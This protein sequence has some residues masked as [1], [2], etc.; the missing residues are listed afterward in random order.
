MNGQLYLLKEAKEEIVKEQDC[1][2]FLQKLEKKIAAIY[3]EFIQRTGN[4]YLY[5]NEQEEYD[6]LK[7]MVRGEV[8]LVF[9]EVYAFF[10]E[11]KDLIKMEPKFLRQMLIFFNQFLGYKEILQEEEKQKIEKILFFELEC[12]EDVPFGYSLSTNQKTN[13]LVSL[14]KSILERKDKNTTEENLPS[15]LHFLYCAITYSTLRIKDYSE[16]EITFICE[17]GYRFLEE[18]V[19]QK[20]RE[21]NNPYLL[22]LEDMLNCYFKNYKPN[23]EIKPLVEK[24]RTRYKEKMIQKTLQKLEEQKKGS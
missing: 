5:P 8:F 22:K 13:H 10:K 17:I 16:E 9:N 12:I 11:S 24:H 3:Q 15:I 2:K 21:V 23:Q 14:G 18:Y 7:K 6:K 20:N 19:Y 1:V 4:F